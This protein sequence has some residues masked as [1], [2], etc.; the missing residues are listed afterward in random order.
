MSYL[1]E[2]PS[3]P[4]HDRYGAYAKLVDDMSNLYY[5]SWAVGLRLKGYLRDISGEHRK[6]VKAHAIKLYR[7]VLRELILPSL[8]SL[9]QE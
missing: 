5:Y 6:E 2:Y 7:R 8:R 1:Y 4:A 9:E 3:P